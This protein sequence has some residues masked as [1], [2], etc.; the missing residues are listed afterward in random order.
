MRNWKNYLLLAGLLLLG[1]C[2]EDSQQGYDEASAQQ[3]LDN[4]KGVYDGTVMVNNLPQAVQI[5]IG[6]DFTMKRLPTEPI[7][8]HIFSGGD[9]EAAV[10]SVET[11][12][13][14]AETGIM[15]V[16]E[17]YRPY[18]FELGAQLKADAK[19]VINDNFS[20]TTQFV[21]FSNYLNKPL[22]MRVNW[23]NK[24]FW[25]MAKY[26]AFTISTNLIY[27][28]LVKVKLLDDGTK[29]PA[30]QFK[31]FFEFGFTYTIANKK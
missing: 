16:G 27:D 25:K 23:D 15:T 3:T 19:W 28:D 29:V 18:R 14:T 2:S 30:V 11:V 31:E 9:L 1:A 12:N 4:M 13:F 7:L 21:L 26:F 5:V 10:N 17:N 8:S 24:M 6:T 22:N 20:Y